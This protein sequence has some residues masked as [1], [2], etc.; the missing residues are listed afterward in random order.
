MVAVVN[1]MRSTVGL[2]RFTVIHA[3]LICYRISSSFT[4]PTIMTLDAAQPEAGPS[5]YTPGPTPYYDTSQYL[6]WR[7]TPEQ[8]S[9]IRAE[10]NAKSVEV[11]SRNSILEEVSS[12]LGRVMLSF[13]GGSERAR[14]RDQTPSAGHILIRRRRTAP[15]QILHFASIDHMSQRV[16]SH[17]DHRSDRD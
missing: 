10:L 1:G 8:L 15:P 2:I 17:R 13:Q 6:H 5:R 11:V 16:W 9:S 7:Y 14:Q 3:A 12:L 4:Q